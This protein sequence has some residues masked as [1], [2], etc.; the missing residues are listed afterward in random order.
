MK[1][2]SKEFKNVKISLKR[3]I[4]AKIQPKY[5]ILAVLYKNNKKSDILALF[6]LF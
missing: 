5:M 6:L 1:N 4:F 2:G 3:A